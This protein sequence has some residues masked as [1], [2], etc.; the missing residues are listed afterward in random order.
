MTH[1]FADPSALRGDLLEIDGGDY[2]HIRNVLRMKPGEELSVSFNGES[3]DYRFRIESYMEKSAVCRLL[4][5]QEADTELPVKVI[6]FQGLPKSDKMELI[7]QKAVELGVHQIVPVENARCVVK[8]DDARKE[9]RIARWRS[10]AESAAKQSRRT[11]IPEIL[12]PLSMQE[13]IRYSGEVC[14][15]GFI[16]YELDPGDTTA[17]AL[18]GIS[19]GDTVAVFIGPEG[20][21]EEKEV[22]EAKAAGILPVSLGRRILRTETAGLAFLSFMIYRFELGGSVY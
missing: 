11:C 16:P 5:V 2:N 17:Q 7:I 12:M 19:P 10:I 6:L 20:G 21:F 3:R 15:R 4:S 13:A 8:L 14:G 9:K 1:L 18:S 22:E